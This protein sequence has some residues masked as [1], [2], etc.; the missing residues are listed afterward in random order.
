MPHH[1]AART[2]PEISAAKLIVDREKKKTLDAGLFQP[3]DPEEANHSRAVWAQTAVTEFQRSTGTEDGD[4]LSDLLC[5][6]MH[7]CDRRDTEVGWGFAAALQ[8]AQRSYA[9]ET[10]GR[11]E[12][13]NG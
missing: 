10:D 8:R 9:E 12:K 2:S 1:I 4:A 13:S 5:N 3:P 6:L 11:Q 7:L